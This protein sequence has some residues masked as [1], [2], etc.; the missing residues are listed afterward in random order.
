[1][2][3]AVLESRLSPFAEAR[4]SGPAGGPRATLE[5]RLE[6]AWRGV[7]TEGRAECPVCRSSMTPDG[8]AGRC[9]GCGSTLS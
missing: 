1:M 2:T 4:R 9:G 3:T 7:Q 5:E 8:G 6:G